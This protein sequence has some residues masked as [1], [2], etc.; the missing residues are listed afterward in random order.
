MGTAFLDAIKRVENCPE[1]VNKGSIGYEACFF[2]ADDDLLQE[3]E[4]DAIGDKT[5]K[6]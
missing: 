4:K 2:S 6:N 5:I 1:L 3:P